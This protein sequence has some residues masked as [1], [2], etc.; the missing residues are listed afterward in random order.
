MPLIEVLP[1]RVEDLNA[2][3]A[4]IGNVHSSLSVDRNV[5]YLHLELPVAG[6]FGAPGEQ[7]LA[8]LVELDDAR[9]GVPVGHVE[10]AVGRERDVGWT[11][12]MR[13]VLLHDSLLAEGQE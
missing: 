13:V 12:K 2:L 7:S 4:S 8:V 6:S 10:R 9:I 3:V 11:A 1:V 5:V